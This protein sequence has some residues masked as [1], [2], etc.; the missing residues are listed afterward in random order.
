MKNLYKGKLVVNIIT[1]VETN[2]KK[3]M[4]DQAHENFTSELFN[5]IMAIVGAKGYIT[6]SIGV[7]LEDRGAAHETQIESIERNKSDALKKAA[8]V[9]SKCNRISI[10]L[11]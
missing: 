3:I 2:D 6:Q 4:T 9:Y 5:E 1:A 7:T 8:S 10:R 11:D